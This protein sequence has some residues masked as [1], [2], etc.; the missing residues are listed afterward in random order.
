V[1]GK[2]SISDTVV[3]DCLCENDDDDDD[4]DDDLDGKSASK[5]S[6]VTNRSRSG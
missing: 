6:A 5:S 2:F 1:R 4:D 3:V